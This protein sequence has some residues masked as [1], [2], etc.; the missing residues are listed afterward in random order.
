M[1]DALG[2]AL[3][4]VATPIKFQKNLP[5][6]N[7]AGSLGINVSTPSPELIPILASPTAPF[8]DKELELGQLKVS[9]ATASPIQ[10]GTGNFKASFSASGSA[11]AG[12]ALYRD[13]AKVLAAISPGTDILP[14]LDLAATADTNFL[15]LRWGF[16]AEAKFNGAVALGAVGTATVAVEGSADGKF[17]V[18]RRL[19]RTLPARSALTQLADSWMLPRQV[20]TITD[21]APGTWLVSEVGGSVGLTLG[22]QAGWDFNWIRETKLGTLQGDIGLRLELAVKAA[23][24]FRAEGHWAVVVARESDAREL[25]LR[26]FRLKSTQTNFSFNATAGLTG[27]NTLLPRNADDLI[28]AIFGTHGAQVLAQLAVVQKWTDPKKKLTDLLTAEGISQAE[29]LVAHLA[30]VPVDQLDNK[31]NDIQKKAVG[32]INAWRNL[33]HTVATTVLKLVG[34]KVDLAPVREIV[35]ALQTATPESLKALLAEELGIAQFL[36]TPAGKLLDAVAGNQGVLGLLNAPLKDVR[37]VAGRIAKVL[38][39]SLIEETLG[40]FQQFVED[41]LNIGN[42]LNAIT[43][44]GFASLDALLKKKLA[45]F[46][47]KTGIKFEDLDQIR[48]VIQNLLTKRQEFYEKALAAFTKTYTASVASNFQ[49]TVTNQAHLDIVFNFSDDPGGVSDFLKLALAGN[50]DRILTESHTGVRLGLATLSHGV[51]RKSHVELSLPFFKASQTRLNEALATVK[52]TDDS[53]RI[54]VLEL[55]ARDS[56]ATNRR[57][58]SLALAL[59]LS[60]SPTAGTELRVH[61]TDSFRYSYTLRQ[62]LKRATRR[63]LDGQLRPL[64]TQYLK[65]QSV[66]GFLNYFDA[67]TEEVIPHTPDF[68]GNTLVNLQVGLSGAAAAFAGD[69]WLKIPPKKEGRLKRKQAMSLAI[70]KT[71]RELMLNQYFQSTERFQTLDPAFVLLAW[72]SLPGVN[73]KG[74]IF[75]NWPEVTLRR[76]HLDDD[77]TRQNLANMLATISVRLSS[78]PGTQQFFTPG[79]AGRILANV[80]TKDPRLEGLLF[81]EAVIIDTAVAAYDAIAKLDVQKKPSKAIEQLAE[82]GSKLTEAFNSNVTNLYLGGVSRALGTVVYLAATKALAGIAADLEPDAM[83]TISALKPDAL[84][85]AD[86]FLSTGTLDVNTVAAQEML[87]AIA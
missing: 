62:T 39:G 26:L 11:F 45:D 77:A 65:T 38:D 81:A 23:F 36:T 27:V 24:G 54:L 48:S 47:G 85:D 25:R 18:V 61:Q 43:D 34:D 22:V 68:I 70:Q 83:L 7:G 69:A 84:L 67:R 75:W 80:K 60:V 72:S 3:A 4:G 42:L 56:V 55:D 40:R 58:S 82:F 20:S 71:L 17:A 78:D 13:P 1:S 16:G 35:A 87:A 5:F 9:A 76:Q 2:A 8:P 32:L 50:F 29:A 63:D 31:F 30:G 37:D 33:D 41:K 28:R 49:K 53:G 14:G 74:G 86:G 57:N 15:V 6:L 66:D 52:A 73:D 44:T 46:L 51:P 79:Q 12:I 64:F 21:L 19:P 10:F 59:S